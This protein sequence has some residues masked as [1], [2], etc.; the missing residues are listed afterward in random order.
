MIAVE[1]VSVGMLNFETVV[2]KIRS[3]EGSSGEMTRI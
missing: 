2:R 3:Q 1:F